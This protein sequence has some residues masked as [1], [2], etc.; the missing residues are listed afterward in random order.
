MTSVMTTKAAGPRPVRQDRQERCTGGRLVVALGLVALTLAIYT[1]VCRS[2]FINYDDTIYVTA[3]RQVQGGLSLDGVR[4]AFTSIDAANWHPLTWLSLQLDASLYGLCPF[5]FHLTNILW[6][7][8]STALLFALLDRLTGRLWESALVAALFGLHP[9]HVESVAWVAERKDVLSGFLAFLALYAYGRYARS[10]GWGNYGLTTLALALGLMAKPMLVTLPCLFLLLD[11]WPLGRWRFGALDARLIEKAPWGLVAFISCAMTVA[12]QRGAIATVQQMPWQARIENAVIAYGKY[13]LNAIWPA[14]LALYYPHSMGPSSWSDV[15]GSA[16]L[17]AM[18]TVW[19][20]TQT[21]KRPYLL[22]GWLWYVVALI[23]VIGL[24]QVG[25][26]AHADRYT[27][28]PL[29]GI[30]VMVT[31]LSG[32]A[33]TI[34]TWSRPLGV[35]TAMVI[36]GACSLGTWRQIGYWRDSVSLWQHATATTGPN[37]MAASNLGEALIWKGRLEEARRSLLQAVFLDPGNVNS[38]YNLGVV[39]ERTGNLDEA[40]QYYLE[41]I[42]RNADYRDSH[43]SLGRLYCQEG[44]LQDAGRHLEEVLRLD[45]N[46]ADAHDHLGWVRAQQGDMAKARWHYQEALRLNPDLTDAR[47]NLELINP[48]RSPPQSSKLPSSG[49]PQR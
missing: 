28:I 44:D 13:L 6:H 7:A 12:A 31:W 39:A 34:G 24:V 48:G 42:K 35:G 23:P 19:T 32:E 43:L 8:A 10:P 40:K 25:A 9:L 2:A 36:L 29:I 16:A 15:A 41:T 26:Q 27:Y 17:L 18:I 45:P 4:W 14:D 1:G 47:L 21:S 3:N 20:L 38:L 22:V 5:G 49:G 11:F 33:L 46:N 30:F 37:F